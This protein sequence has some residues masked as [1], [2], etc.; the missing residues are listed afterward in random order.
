MKRK[1]CA[2]TEIDVKKKA[3]KSSHLDAV[4]PSAPE[5]THFRSTYD[6]E[7]YDGNFGENMFYVMENENKHFFS[8]KSRI[9]IDV[10]AK[11]LSWWDLEVVKVASN[12]HFFTVLDLW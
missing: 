12:H 5:N 4:G 7:W 6:K 9:S 1:E 3:R 10:N 8:Y 2:S 11:R